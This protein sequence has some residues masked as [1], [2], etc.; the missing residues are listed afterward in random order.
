MTLAELYLWH[1]EAGR[2]FKLM[3]GSK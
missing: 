2:V 1:G 3:Q